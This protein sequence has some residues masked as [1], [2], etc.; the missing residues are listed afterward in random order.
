MNTIPP[1]ISGV[2]RSNSLC[3]DFGDDK[4][5]EIDDRVTVAGHKK[6]TIRFIGETKF[7]QGEY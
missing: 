4:N 1:I 3:S 5:F 6:G 7:A 2:S